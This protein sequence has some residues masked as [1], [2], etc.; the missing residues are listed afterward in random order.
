MYVLPSIVGGPQT[1]SKN[2]PN[3]LGIYSAFSPVAKGFVANAQALSWA[4]WGQPYARVAEVRVFESN[5]PFVSV[6]SKSVNTSRFK[7]YM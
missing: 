1:V 3:T 5:T 2:G 7:P 4:K 6:P